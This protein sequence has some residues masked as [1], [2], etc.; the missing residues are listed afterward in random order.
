MRRIICTA[1]WT[2]RT[3]TRRNKPGGTELPV[4]LPK[5]PACLTA[6][7]TLEHIDSVIKDA[8]QRLEAVERSTPT[9]STLSQEG[10]PV[11]KR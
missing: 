11:F 8:V 9:T 6:L 4:Q 1:Q 10:I 7:D 3:P 2:T 5:K